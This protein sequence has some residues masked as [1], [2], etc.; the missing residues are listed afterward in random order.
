ML[1][2]ITIIDDYLIYKKKIN[3]LKQVKKKL[4]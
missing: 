3:Y 1:I 2:Y 4:R